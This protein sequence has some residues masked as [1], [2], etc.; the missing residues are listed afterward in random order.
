[1]NSWLIFNPGFKKPVLVGY[2][3][4][5]SGGLKMASDIS[6]FFNSS[7]QTPRSGYF[8]SIEFRNGIQS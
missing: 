4:Q 5:K 7:I 6:F 3:R 8:E 2:Y 1:M